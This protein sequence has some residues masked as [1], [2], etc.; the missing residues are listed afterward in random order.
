M[1]KKF[2]KEYDWE[3]LRKRSLLYFPLLL[4]YNKTLR[5]HRENRLILIYYEETCI[6]AHSAV[7]LHSVYLFELSDACGFVFPGE[8]SSSQIAPFCFRRTGTY[9]SLAHRACSQKVRSFW[10]IFHPGTAFDSEPESYKAERPGKDLGT[11]VSDDHS[12]I[13]RRDASA[14]YIRTFRTDQRCVA[15]YGRSGCRNSPVFSGSRSVL[16]YRT[17]TRHRGQNPQKQK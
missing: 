15:G 10:G 13:Y 9:R 3:K 8:R 17:E 6:L 5:K 11:A 14:V 12:S 1:K 7:S 4:Y 2:G 16:P